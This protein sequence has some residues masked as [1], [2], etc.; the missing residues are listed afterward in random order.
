MTSYVKSFISFLN[1]STLNEVEQ[2]IKSWNE[3]Y[4]QSFKFEN[5]KA[6]VL[7]DIRADKKESAKEGLKSLA[8]LLNINHKV[9][10]IIEAHTSSPQAS[11]EWDNSNE[12]LSQARANNIKQYLIQLG[13]NEEQ[14]KASGVGATKPLKGAE[15]DTENTEGGL[16]S[17]E[18]Q[19]KNRRATIKID[20]EKNPPTPVKQMPTDIKAAFHSYTVLLKD[21]KIDNIF[22]GQNP[23]LNKYLI[24]MDFVSK[25]SIIS[26][27]CPTKITLNSKKIELEKLDKEIKT[28]QTNI[29]RKKKEEVLLQKKV[30]EFKLKKGFYTEALK[31]YEHM[32]KTAIFI[33]NISEL[34][35]KIKNIVNTDY[36]QLKPVPGS[37]LD[38]EIREVIIPN[39][40]NFD[41]TTYLIG[42]SSVS[43]DSYRKE[44]AMSRAIFMKNLL[45]KIDPSI[46]EKMIV[47]R[48]DPSKNNNI[49]ISIKQQK[50][51]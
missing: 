34:Q 39:I 32:T 47:V 33:T 18:K 16:T 48:A 23:K 12:K 38:V 40:K 8:N 41:G 46:G 7:D 28:L 13:V 51:D 10:I 30:R 25:Y 24:G 37:D 4:S 20:Y 50:N 43:N 5:D 49:A 22:T 42:H 14:L 17:K 11:S 6:K 2:Q 26:N 27:N 9:S 45:L 36:E 31:T 44:L 35:T 3:K 29:K 19:A 15:N 21:R 1:E